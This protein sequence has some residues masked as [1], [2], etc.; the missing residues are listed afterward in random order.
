MTDKIKRDNTNGFEDNQGKILGEVTLKHL[1]KKE[2]YYTYLQK[3]VD[4]NM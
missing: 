4:R 2:D 3:A 1:D